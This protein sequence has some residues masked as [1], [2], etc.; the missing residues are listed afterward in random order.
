M[1][2]INPVTLI[3]ATICEHSVI[4]TPERGS[5]AGLLA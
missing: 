2:D 5:I 4:N 3:E 1:F